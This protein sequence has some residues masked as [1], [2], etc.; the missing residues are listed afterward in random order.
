M[1]NFSNLMNEVEALRES[2]G[3][4]I[5]DAII[6]IRNNETEYPSEVRRELKEFMFQ[7]ARMF[8]PKNG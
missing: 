6:Y 7:G 3:Y 5:L 1:N 4:S 8:A 2:W